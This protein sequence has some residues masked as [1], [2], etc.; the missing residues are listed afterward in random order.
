MSE[1]TKIEISTVFYSPEQFV[2]EIDNQTKNQLKSLKTKN[3]IFKIFNS[4]HF[5]IEI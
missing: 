1:I 2:T 4:T 5:S 3:F